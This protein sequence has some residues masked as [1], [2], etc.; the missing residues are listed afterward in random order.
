MRQHTL[1]EV[2]EQRILM[3][4]TLETGLAELGVDPS[5]ILLSTLP[6]AS[7]SRVEFGPVLGGVD[8]LNITA[9]SAPVT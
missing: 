3:S 8:L 4:G 5:G 1:F 9:D 7:S 2:L 6:T